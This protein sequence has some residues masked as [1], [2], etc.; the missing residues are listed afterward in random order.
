MLHRAL[1][2]TTQA[3]ILCYETV[4]LHSFDRAMFWANQLK[5]HEPSCRIFLVATKVDLLECD[6]IVEEVPQQDA[7]TF[8]QKIG[9]LIIG[10]VTATFLNLDNFCKF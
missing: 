10:L 7:L 1:L 5:Q 4:S 6:G 8:K 2:I 9:V 3:A